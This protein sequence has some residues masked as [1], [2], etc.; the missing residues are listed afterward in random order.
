MQQGLAA[1]GVRWPVGSSLWTAQMPN[2][3]RASVVETAAVQATPASPPGWATRELRVG[4]VHKCSRSGHDLGQVGAED[5]RRTLGLRGEA[6][7]T[8]GVDGAT[9]S[10]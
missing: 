8:E 9:L 6:L 7:G 2:L 5:L 1:V 3:R 4:R 10:G